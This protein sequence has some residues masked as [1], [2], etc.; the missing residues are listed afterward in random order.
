MERHLREKTFSPDR[1]LEASCLP[2]LPGSV[3]VSQGIRKQKPYCARDRVTSHSTSQDFSSSECEIK[4]FI[5]YS[6][7]LVMYS[8]S[9]AQGKP[10]MWI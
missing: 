9:D 1:H 8:V 2:T 4:H 10:D 6:M 5:A 7:Q 3:L